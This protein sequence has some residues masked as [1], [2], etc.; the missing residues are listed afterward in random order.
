MKYE[1]TTSVE[2]SSIKKE[3]VSWLVFF[4]AEDVAICKVQ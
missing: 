1:E 2:L 3:V 4:A